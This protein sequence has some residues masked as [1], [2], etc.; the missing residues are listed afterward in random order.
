[1]TCQSFSSSGGIPSQSSNWLPLAV[2]Y[3]MLEAWLNELLFEKRDMA[4]NCCLGAGGA[5]YYGADDYGASVVVL[6]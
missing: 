5:D 3:V 2:K 4:I 6:A 1:M